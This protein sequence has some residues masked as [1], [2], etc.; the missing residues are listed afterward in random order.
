[1]LLL[2]A[3][4]SLLFVHLAHPFPRVEEY[5]SESNGSPITKRQVV[6]SGNGS[7][8]KVVCYFEDWAKNRPGKGSFGEDEMLN[9][10][11]THIIYSFSTLDA[12]SNKIQYSFLPT[13]IQKLKEKGVKVMLAVGGAVDSTGD[14]YSHMVSNPE[15]RRVFVDSVLDMMKQHDF[16]GFDVDWEY[17]TCPT[18]VA[19]CG[20]APADKENFVQLIQELRKALPG[21]LLTMAS[22]AGQNVVDQAY[23]LPALVENLDWINVMTYDL[24]GSWETEALNHSPLKAGEGLSTDSAVQLYKSKGVPAEKIVI[25]VPTYGKSLKLADPTKHEYKSP[26]AGGGDAGPYMQ[27]AGFLGY[28]E[29]CE[30][31]KSSGWTVGSATDQVGPYAYNGDQFVGFD[32]VGTAERKATYA[33]EQGLGGVM[34]WALGSDDFSDVCGCGKYP[35]VSALYKVLVEHTPASQCRL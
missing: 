28:L 24:H 31:V 15:S 1:M 18:G 3:V 13:A 10:P 5:D 19:S 17:P 20:G 33:R 27:E 21:K 16:D 8:Y 35:L 6:T 2:P 32:D 29:I 26:V 11:C 4:I 30:K 23:D 7:G 34:V 9:A 14:K 22:H 25:G 12:S